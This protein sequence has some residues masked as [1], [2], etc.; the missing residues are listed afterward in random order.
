MD[1][2]APKDDDHTRETSQCDRNLRGNT[3]RFARLDYLN[4]YSC[5]SKRHTF[6]PKFATLI[7]MRR[8][9]GLAA[10]LATETAR[11]DRIRRNVLM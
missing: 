6:Q 7:T 10:A 1:R 4:C 8:P 11:K 3:K 9:P 5:L 2:F